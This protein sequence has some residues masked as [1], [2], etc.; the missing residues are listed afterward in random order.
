M[1]QKT[2]I[3]WFALGI[4]T[5]RRYDF[6]LS[7]FGDLDRALRALDGTVLGELGCKPETIER[8]TNLGCRLQVAKDAFATCNLQQYAT[9]MEKQ[10]ICL[11]TWEDVTYPAMLREIGDPPMF[12]S[13]RGDLSILER[14]CLGIV[15]TRAMSAYG[16]RVVEAC[17]PSFVAYGVTTVSGLALGVDSAVARQTLAAGGKTVAVLGHGL[18]SIYPP[19]NTDLARQIVDR[20]GLLLSEFPLDSIPTKY[21]FPS[22]NRIIA[23][24]SRGV[25]VVEAGAKSG[26]LITADLAIDYGREAFAVPG[27]IF[28]EGSAGCH[29]IIVRGEAKLATSPMDILQDIGVIA[30]AS[31]KDASMADRYIAQNPDEE[32]V[33]TMLSGSPQSSSKIV[34]TSGMEPGTVSAALTALELAGV[35]GNTMEGWIRK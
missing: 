14:P 19:T 35:A 28:S 24:L 25:L 29:E 18:G 4:L 23:G 27:S 15:G 17:I 9:R 2:A 13:Y 30:G 20:G 11:V 33:I 31:A 7:R 32:R 34:E 26:A 12:L 5:K 10:G 21:T 3:T 22:R 16:K 8:M 6:L 1:D